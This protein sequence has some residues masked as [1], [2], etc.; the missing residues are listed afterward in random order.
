MDTSIEVQTNNEQDIDEQV[1][2]LMAKWKEDPDAFY[3][4]KDV[5]YK[6]FQADLRA[7]IADGRIKAVKKG[8]Q[9]VRVC[10]ATRDRVDYALS[11]VEDVDPKT[12]EVTVA[13]S[14]DK[15]RSGKY[16]I[17]NGVALKGPD[18]GWLAPFSTD[19]NSPPQIAPPP[20]PVNK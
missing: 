8:D 1:A 20:T 2:H 17:S 16:S 18:Y 4:W 5:H 11:V 14:G 13:F 10:P 3:E 15:P 19:P 7:N 6:L 9:L 12:G